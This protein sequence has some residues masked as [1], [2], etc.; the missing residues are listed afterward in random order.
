MIYKP[1]LLYS[2]V[3]YKLFSYFIYLFTEFPFQ[4]NRHALPH[5]KNEI[6]LHDSIIC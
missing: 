3:L 5:Y 4:V 6:S 1:Y 2:T